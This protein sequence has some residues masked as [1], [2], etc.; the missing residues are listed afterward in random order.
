MELEKQKRKKIIW[1]ENMV[2]AAGVL[3]VALEKCLM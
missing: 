1:K 2:D 3:T